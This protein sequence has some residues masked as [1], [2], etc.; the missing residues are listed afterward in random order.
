MKVAYYLESYKC[1]PENTFR[2]QK[3]RCFLVSKKSLI[4]LKRGA[5]AY[6]I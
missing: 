3:V 1:V 6:M 5:I 2:R 4:S